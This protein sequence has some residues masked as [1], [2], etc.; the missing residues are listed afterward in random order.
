MSHVGCAG[1]ADHQAWTALRMAQ[2]RERGQGLSLA[3]RRGVDRS[4]IA[5]TTALLN[6]AE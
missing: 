4:V 6:H 3:R 5:D 1:V 2:A